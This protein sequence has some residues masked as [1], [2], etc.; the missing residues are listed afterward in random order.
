[1]KLWIRSQDRETLRLA[2]MLD[3]YELEDD[4]EKRFVIEESGVDIGCYKSKE[5][6]LEVLDE[7]QNK[8]KTLLY[9]KPK[10]K[11]K[12]DTIKDAKDYF[13][14]LN[15]IELITTDI[16]FEIEPIL[17]NVIVYEMPKE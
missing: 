12:L 11:L 10:T 1:M 13:E 3:I 17:T 6:A 16:N 15:G 5:R 7:I 8:I 9:L 4:E 14:H 2:E